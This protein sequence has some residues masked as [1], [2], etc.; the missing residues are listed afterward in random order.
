MSSSQS[1]IRSISQCRKT[2]DHSL[3]LACYLSIHLRIYLSSYPSIY[4][5]IHISLY[6]LS[7]SL[8][9]NKP[10]CASVRRWRIDKV[11]L[12]LYCTMQM[13]SPLQVPSTIKPT[14]TNI[15]TVCKFNCSEQLY[16]FVN[17]TAAAATPQSLPL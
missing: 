14:N 4:L 5:S 6:H 15:T 7:V 12:V 10:I 16:F 8:A 2:I 3:F 13:Y 1:L 9:L 11:N 17:F